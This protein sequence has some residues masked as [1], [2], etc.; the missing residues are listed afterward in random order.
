VRICE[1]NN[2]ADN[3]VREEGGRRGAPGARAVIPLQPL[4]K[5]VVRQAVPLKSMVEQIS[6][7]SPC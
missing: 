2:S 6:T 4:E 7:C 3:K 5:T 1:R